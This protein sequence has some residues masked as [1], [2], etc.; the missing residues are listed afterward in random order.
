MTIGVANSTRSSIIDS[1]TITLKN[2]SSSVVQS[3]T[4]PKTL[5]L[6]TGQYLVFGATT[7]T[8]LFYYTESGS[9]TSLNCSMY[10]H[11]PS[12]PDGGG[13]NAELTIDA[14]YDS[15]I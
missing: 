1:T 2:V 10:H 13:G 4:L 11:I 3:Y 6:S 8:G 5:N 12:A 14:G 15:S 7:D 9:A